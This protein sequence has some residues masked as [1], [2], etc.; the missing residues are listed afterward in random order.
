LVCLVW[1]NI[2]LFLIMVYYICITVIH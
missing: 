2:C 1:K